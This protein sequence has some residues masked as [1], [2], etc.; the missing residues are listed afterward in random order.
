[1]NQRFALGMYCGVLMGVVLG[2]LLG[3]RD[4]EVRLANKHC[5]QVSDRHEFAACK[6]EFL[7]G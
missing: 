6:K 3:I 4:M 2:F 1:M 5:Q 7:G